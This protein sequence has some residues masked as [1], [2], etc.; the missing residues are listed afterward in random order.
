MDRC[1]CT[2]NYF[3]TSSDLCRLLITYASNLDQDQNRRKKVNFE[4]K[5]ADANK[6]MT[7]Y[8]AC[9]ELKK[10]LMHVR[11]DDEHSNALLKLQLART[12]SA[13]FGHSCK[14]AGLLLMCNQ[15][16]LKRVWPSAHSHKCLQCV[17]TQHFYTKIKNRSLLDSCF[18]MIKMLTCMCI[19]DKYTMC[20]Q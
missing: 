13:L 20:K 12:T 19:W 4:K 1:A 15:W 16:R 5:R 3:L 18:C 11:L 8:P 17:Q 2:F 6:S 10:G 9:K 7:N 14:M